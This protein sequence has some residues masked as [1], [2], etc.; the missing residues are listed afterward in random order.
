MHH[1]I[2]DPPAPGQESV[3]KYPRPAIAERTAAHVVVILGGVTIARRDPHDRDQPS[4]DLLSATGRHP[5]R[6]AAPGGWYQLLRVEGP[7]PLFRRYGGRTGA[8][9][10][11]GFAIPYVA[12]RLAHYFRL[13]PRRWNLWAIA[14]ESYR[15]YKA[16][17]QASEARP[18]VEL[19]REYAAR[20]DIIDFDRALPDLTDEELKS[21]TGFRRVVRGQPELSVPPES[22]ARLFADWERRKG[23][24]E[25]G[26]YLR[27]DGEHLTRKR[28]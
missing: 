5:A 20:R 21:T 14:M 28:S 11:E 16:S 23:S 24:P 25:I 2:A 26:Q 7:R 17:V 4:A 13:L 3:W 6:R 1:P 10:V 15:R 19:I 9:I 12:G 8:R 27:R 18:A 22:I